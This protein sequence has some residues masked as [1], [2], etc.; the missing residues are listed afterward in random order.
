MLNHT[1]KIKEIYKSIQEQIYYMIPERWDELYLYSSIV[2]NP[3]I[4][5]NKGELF[6]YYLP[7]GIIKK[8]IVNVYEIPAKFNI[9]E[10]QYFRLVERL[11]KQIK[12]LQEEFKKSE[13]ERI[14]SNITIVI[15]NNK[16]KTIYDDTD[17]I[18][19]RFNNYDRHIIWRYE[20]LGITPDMLPK[21]E[22]QIIYDYMRFGSSNSK[23]NYYEEG[24]Y[25]DENMSNIIGYSTEEYTAKKN[26][27]MQRNDYNQKVNIREKYK[28]SN[29]CVNDSEKEVGNIETHISPEIPKKIQY[30]NQILASRNLYMEDE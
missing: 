29:I 15:K 1:K 4:G 21:D 13:T 25:I 14:W 16:F 28:V 7:K 23:K 3:K 18:N 10:K 26:I 11:Y 9:H 22:K 17:L 20:Y 30:K 12:D 19:N 8:K 27:E 6:F 24:V 2:E 5:G